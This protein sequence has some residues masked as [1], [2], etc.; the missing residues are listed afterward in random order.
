MSPHFRL[1]LLIKVLLIKVL[2]IKAKASIHK[3]IAKTNKI[4]I[5]LDQ[6]LNITN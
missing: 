5:K 6:A 1:V 2:I 3:L 4:V